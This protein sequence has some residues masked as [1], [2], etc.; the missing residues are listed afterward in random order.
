ML[1]LGVAAI[2]PPFRGGVAGASPAD[3]IM[4]KEMK[5]L[6]GDDYWYISEVY[7][8]GNNIII[9]TIY[10]T[11]EYG[12]NDGYMRDATIVHY[13]VRPLNIFDKIG[14]IKTFEEKVKRKYDTIKK[15]CDT[16][17]K[18]LYDKFIFNQSICD[19]IHIP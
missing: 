16:H 4:D 13:K 17:N 14:G 5:N 2:L 8:D 6:L 15:Q 9:R 10:G 7:P 12:D 3:R 1:C 19:K 18:R 11:R